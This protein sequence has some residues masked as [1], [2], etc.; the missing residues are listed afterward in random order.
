MVGDLVNRGPSSL[1]V[2]R[3]A[4]G[5]SAELGERMVVVLGNHDVHLLA[6]AAGRGRPSHRRYLD[7][8][9]EA[10]DRDELLAWLRSRPLVHRGQ[11][12][13][14]PEHLLV[15][16]GLPPAWTAA[17]AM[18]RGRRAEEL[19]RSPAGLERLLEEGPDD[20]EALEEARETLRAV[21]T[22]RMLTP[23]GAASDH[24]G[25]PEKGPKGAVAW[26]DRPDRRSRDHVVVTGHWAALGRRLRP[27]LVA[28]DSGCVYGGALTAVRLED[29]RVLE[30]PN[31]E[32]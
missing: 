28:L 20:D 23:E 18:A 14:G 4:R 6:L 31:R 32:S 7:E 8:V 1:A 30:Q 27:D 10:P 15:H 22:L 17:E 3:W 19:L 29:R 11:I 24:T 13:A 26:F 5:L 12:A 21:T 2:L 9:L 16:A 25:P